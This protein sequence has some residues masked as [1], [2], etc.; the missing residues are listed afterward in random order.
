MAFT[1]DGI[2]IVHKICMVEGEE[3]QQ[4]HTEILFCTPIPVILVPAL[5]KGTHSYLFQ[6]LSRETSSEN[7][8]VCL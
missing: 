7:P 8:D 3:A 4:A 2:H 1:E 5:F 6:L